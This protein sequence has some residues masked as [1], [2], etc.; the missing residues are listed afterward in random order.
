M[1]QIRVARVFLLFVVPNLV[2]GVL[3]AVFKPDT[4]M[5]MLNGAM[6]AVASGVCVAYFPIIRQVLTDR[7]RHIDRAD[8]LALGIFCSWFAIVLRAAWS[9]AWRHQGKPSAW[10]DS[11][12]LSYFI[13]LGVCAAS[14]HLLAPGAIDQ[15]IPSREWLWVG[16]LCAL[17]V[18]SIMV[19]S[20]MLDAFPLAAR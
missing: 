6:L 7:H 11:H 3:A 12:F 2:F 14:F 16:M 4:L 15:R 10:I 18:L 19:A 20:W 9:L 5:P 17:G 13:F 8:M 1:T